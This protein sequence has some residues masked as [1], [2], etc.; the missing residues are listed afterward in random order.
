[1]A[2]CNQLTPLPFRGLM[3]KQSMALLFK[4]FIDSN[5]TIGYPVVFLVLFCFLFFNNKGKISL[6][7]KECELFMLQMLECRLCVSIA[8]AAKMKSFYSDGILYRDN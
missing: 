7:S 6:S 8:V 2:K 4:V 3:C 1:M 5:A